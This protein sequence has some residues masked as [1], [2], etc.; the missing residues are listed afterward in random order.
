MSSS[1]DVFSFDRP[2]AL[3]ILTGSGISY[4]SGSG[5]GRGDEARFGI[6][7]SS[8]SGSRGLYKKT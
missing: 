2:C 5:R 6:S 8:D 7:Y 4:S 1:S 3:E